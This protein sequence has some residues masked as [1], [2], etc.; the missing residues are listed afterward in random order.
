MKNTK[1]KENEINF[2][3]ENSKNYTFKEL[4]E[5]LD[6]TEHA[7]R[8]Y[9][10][11]YNLD[12]IKCNGNYIRKQY[13]KKDELSN[14]YDWTTIQEYYNDNHT[15]RDIVEEFNINMRLIIDAKEQNLF[16]SR[17]KSEATKLTAKLK[18]RTHTDETKKKISEIR[19]KYLREN[20]D[21]V[22]YKLNHYSK[23]ES[24][25]E[26]YFSKIYCFILSICLL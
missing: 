11:K 21:K 24:Y 20:P 9:I 25:P 16:K 2:L 14:K 5:K 10:K 3:I 8:K 15:W 6:R 1:W 19:I 18:P 26:Q 12:Y 23:G 7:I 13:I 22:P 4:I 17:T